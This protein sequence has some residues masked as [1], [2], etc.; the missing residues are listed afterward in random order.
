MIDLTALVF[1]AIGFYFEY[2]NWNLTSKYSHRITLKVHYLLKYLKQYY[3]LYKHSVE[4]IYYID[5]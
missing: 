5:E 3:K 1:P 2:V 4:N